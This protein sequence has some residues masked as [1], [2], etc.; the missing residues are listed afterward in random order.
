MV[1]TGREQ[2]FLTF[3]AVAEALSEVEVS[4][5]QVEESPHAPP[6]NRGSK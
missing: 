5:D 1:S 6:A 3:D 4:R 2:G